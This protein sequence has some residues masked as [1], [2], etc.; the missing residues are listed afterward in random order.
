MVG[1]P[2]GKEVLFV[3]ERGSEKYPESVGE[4]AAGALRG[5]GAERIL[6]RAQIS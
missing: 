2:D 5:L 6:S 1:A 3:E 4:K